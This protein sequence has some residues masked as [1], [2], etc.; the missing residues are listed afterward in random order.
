MFHISWSQWENVN[1]D[2][3]FL[4]EIRW[5][6]SRFNRL[7]PFERAYWNK[8]KGMKV[9]KLQY[10]LKEHSGSIESFGAKYKIMYP[11]PPPTNNYMVKHKQPNQTPIQNIST[12]CWRLF[13][14]E[15]QSIKIK[16]IQ[17][18]I[19]YRIGKSVQNLGMYNICKVLMLT[20]VF[21]LKYWTRH[22]NNCF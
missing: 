15:I 16:F 19:H 10:L 12:T 13:P 4:W 17:K 1:N 5:T 21:D 22:D 2:H 3:Q 6:S 18:K 9:W 14:I 11:C 7:S 20:W 8:S